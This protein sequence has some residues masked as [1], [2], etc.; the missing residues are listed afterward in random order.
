[1]EVRQNSDVIARAY[2]HLQITSVEQM[3]RHKNLIRETFPGSTQGYPDRLTD[4]DVPNEP[5]TNGKNIVFLHGYNVN[6][7]RARGTFAE[8][9]KRLFWSGSNA[10]F[11]GVSWKGNESQIAGS[12]TPDYHTNVA[13]AFQTAPKLTAFLATLT[14]Q[15][16]VAAHSLG[17]MVVLSAITDTTAPIAKYM[18]IDA[19]APIEAIDATVPWSTNMI[20]SEWV[21]YT[22]RLW[23]SRW[24][25]LFASGDG[26]NSLTWSNR[27]SDFHSTEM[28]NFYSSGEEVLRTHT[29]LTP[30]FSGYVGNAIIDAVFK[31]TPLSAYVWALQEKEKG[32]TPLNTVLGSF[33]GG[34]KFNDTSY[35][36]NHVA[37]PTEHMSPANGALLP[38]PQLRTNA[39]F[40][41]IGPGYTVDLALYGTSGSGFAQT[42]RNRLL[43]DTIPALTLPIGANS[44]TNLDIRAGEK[45][46]FDMNTE[47]KNGWPLTRSSGEGLNWHHSDFREVAYLFTWPMFA[48]L[49]QQGDLK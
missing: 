11:Y 30:D 41:L 43:S 12:L 16:V 48:K 46:N 9:F 29:G 26:R 13:N 27:L 47:L 7:D 32:R 34:W 21:S 23:A 20:H 42:N 6:P 38:D 17:N 15:T 8:T 14:N 37:G 22:N 28:Y 19:A 24:F 3:F 4:A 45:R 31:G 5:E 35:G 25:N 44:A 40:D 49:V 1:V 36:T 39:F 2:L 18:M 10:R 33:H